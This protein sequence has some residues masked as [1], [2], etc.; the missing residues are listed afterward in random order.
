MSTELSKYTDGYPKGEDVCGHPDL[1]CYVTYYD[2]TSMQGG[3]IEVEADVPLTVEPLC[4]DLETK[5]KAEQLVFDSNSCATRL[6]TT[7]GTFEGEMFLEFRDGKVEI[8]DS[9][10]RLEPFIDSLNNLTGYTSPTFEEAPLTLGEIE[11]GVT[12]SDELITS[13]PS[14]AFIQPQNSPNILIQN[15]AVGANIG[16]YLTCAAAIIPTVLFAIGASR[17]KKGEQADVEPNQSTT[18][19]EDGIQTSGHVITSYGNGRTTISQLT[20]VER[21]EMGQKF[22]R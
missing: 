15:E 13:Q 1:S 21:K 22:N 19:N 6:N 12:K 4:K 9:S 20:E 18:T 7:D 10:V 3:I 17:S 11:Q 14:V 5:A 16:L 8:G 2:A